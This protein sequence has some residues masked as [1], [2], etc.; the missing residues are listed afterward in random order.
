MK[1]KLAIAF[2]FSGAAALVYQVLWVRMLGLVFGNTTYAV[3]TVLA[4]FMGGMALG[5]WLLGRYSDR[6]GFRPVRT[7]AMIEAGIGAYCAVSPLLFSGASGIYVLAQQAELSLPAVTLTRFLLS[8]AILL[9]PTFLMGGTLPVMTRALKSLLPEG[10]LPGA[11]G[12]FYGVNTLGAVAGVLFTAFAALA[13]LGV[14]GALAL[15]VCLNLAVAMLLYRLSPGEKAADAPARQLSSGPADPALARL[16]LAAAAVSGFASM[17]C[18]VAWTRSLALVIGMSVYAFAVMLAAF[19]AGIAG[20]G[21][22]F[23]R[24]VDRRLGEEAGEGALAAGAA[25]GA[26]GVLVLTTVPAFNHLPP[27][28]LSLFGLVKGTFAG[29]L[30]AELLLSFLVMLPPALLFGLIFPLLIKLYSLASGQDVRPGSVGR[31]YAFNTAGCIAGSLL[32]GFFLISAIGLEGSIRA[33]GFALAAFALAALLSLKAR[34]SHAFAAA[35]F[36]ALASVPH[37][38]AV[39]A[40]NKGVMN[41]GIYQYAPDILARAA[42][43]GLSPAEAFRQ[44]VAGEEQVFYK[45]GANYTVAVTRNLGNGVLSLAIDGKVDA[46]SDYASDMQTQLLSGHLP[47]LLKQDAKR[48]LIIGLASGVT[49]GAVARHPS[50]EEIDCVEIEPAMQEAA[51]Y[52]GA[53][54]GDVLKDAR[55]RVIKDD[56]R[57]Y[58]LTSAKKYDVIISVPSNPWIPGSASLFTREYFDLAKSRL[59]AGG[60]FCQWMHIYEI[61]LPDYKSVLKTAAGVFGNLSLWNPSPGDTFFVSTP[62]KVS[63]DTA[64][65][66]AELKKPGFAGLAAIKAG[67]VPELL[68]RF[69]MAGG[70]LAAFLAGGRENTDLRPLIEFSAP[71]ALYDESAARANFAAVWRASAGASPYISG[72]ADKA[73]LARAYLERGSAA[74]AEREAAGALAERGGAGEGLLLAGSLQAQGRLAEAEAAYNKVLAADPG[75]VEALIALSQMYFEK[76]DY[77]RA[78]DY[79]GRAAKAGAKGAAQGNNQAGLICMKQKKLKEAAGYF[80]RSQTADPAYLPAYINEAVLYLDYLDVPPAALDAL[81]KGL[82]KAKATPLAYYQM[83]RAFY[84]IGFLDQAENSFSQAVASDPGFEPLIRA[85]IAR[86]PGPAGARS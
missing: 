27:L 28:F 76:D 44:A 3:S 35:A 39:G 84:R 67:T 65:L 8:S 2:F 12:F 20:G 49:A 42:A 66:A 25:L 4:A 26:A 82:K 18:E 10:E 59:A 83:G 34:R 53:Y 23:A 50:V 81:E 31:V 73:A 37:L 60:V 7:L 43:Q 30:G 11:I 70:E 56:A 72:R 62:E 48:V 32:T 1:K 75:R 57:N 29:L 38:M 22:I 61:S 46:S 9:V 21:L 45:D 64:L 16:A 78:M 69:V 77:A 79:A 36:I 15:A 63:F 54:N 24:F 58:L 13:W 71:R 40:W 55:L 74:A 19:L 14:Y 6:P 51:A 33:A 80:A 47:L 68:S 17:V 86:R 41:S 85:E 52:F 5:S